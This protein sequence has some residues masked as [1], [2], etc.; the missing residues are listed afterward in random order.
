MNK[1][2]LIPVARDFALKIHK[3]VLIKTVSD[4][5]RPGIAH[6]QEVA[7]LVWASGGTDQEIAAAWLHDS[8]EDTFT[9][10]E[11][12]NR[13]FGDE[14]GNMVKE[15][16]DLKGFKDLP[17]ADRKRKQAERIASA[18]PSVKRVKIA[19]QASNVRA[20][21]LDPTDTMTPQEC[22][23]YI[24][25]AKLIADECRGVS[26]MLDQLFADAYQKAR[27]RHEAI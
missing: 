4:L 1:E 22:K 6:I 7:D 5:Q 13:I 2:M 16:T 10:L 14:I 8:V 3:G 12:I 26:P 23:D 18:G 20:L 17:V 9:T 27:T 25:G 19:D 11:D 24:E 21:A 15:L